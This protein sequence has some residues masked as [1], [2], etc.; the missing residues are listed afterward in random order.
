MDQKNNKISLV[1]DNFFRTVMKNH[2]VAREFLTIHLPEELRQVINFDNLI[3]QPRSFIDDVRKETV[4]DVLY[5]T[6]IETHDAYLYL[7]LEHQSTPD[8][9][10]PFR[11]LKYICNIIAHHLEVTNQNTIPLIYP[12]VVYHAERPYPFSTDINDLVDAPPDLVKR[13]FLKP[14]QL[15]DLA[16]IE[17]QELKNHAWAGAM[18]FALKHIFARDIFPYLRDITE[19][20][21]RIDQSGGRDYISIVLQYVLERAELKDK[22]AFFTLINTKISSEV[23]ENIMTIA[24]QLRTEG[25]LEKG[26][27]I[28]KRLLSKNLELQFI[29][30]MTGLSLNT[31]KEL[32]NQDQIYI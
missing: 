31:L 10:M 13:Y 14:F 18:E 20:L 11:I 24:E 5:K 15:I 1:H 12:M 27:E 19:L 28:A 22:E 3:F 30:E 9:L 7:L 25:K 29:A 16:K 17:D 6:K 2:R 32:Q 26:Y 8:K 4:V 23:G 21:H